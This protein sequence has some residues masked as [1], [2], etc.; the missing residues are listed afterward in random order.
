[1][2][3]FEERTDDLL[4]CASN[5]ERENKLALR[6]II[7][8]LVQSRIAPGEFVK[9]LIDSSIAIAMAHSFPRGKIRTRPLNFEGTEANRKR[10]AEMYSKVSPTID[11]MS[12]NQMFEL[13]AKLTVG[14]N[15]L[16]KI[17]NPI[18]SVRYIEVKTGVAAALS[19]LGGGETNAPA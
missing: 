15:L 17:L 10:L 2:S 3:S 7:E 18:P 8:V 13:I 6:Q 11:R 19:N 16:M 9:E 12:A 14:N 5:A 1:M 4:S